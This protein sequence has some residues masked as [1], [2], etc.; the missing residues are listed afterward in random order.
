MAVVPFSYVFFMGSWGLLLWSDSTLHLLKPVLVF[1]TSQSLF[2]CR[3][4]LILSD[5][6]IYLFLS[7]SFLR[8]PVHHLLPVNFFFIVCPRTIWKITMV[9]ECIDT[10]P[11]SEQSFFWNAWWE[12]SLLSVLHLPSLSSILSCNRS[13]LN[14]FLE[15][16]ISCAAGLSLC[17]SCSRK[18][19]INI[20]WCYTFSQRPVPLAFRE[21]TWAS[22]G[23]RTPVAFVSPV[24]LLVL[25]CVVFWFRCVVSV[26]TLGSFLWFVCFHLFSPVSPSPHIEKHCWSSTHVAA[27]V[28]G[29]GGSVPTFL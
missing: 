18:A 17:L 11:A 7:T 24:E 9:L 5:L 15:C 12:P 26:L 19:K 22:L 1:K 2:S 25:C 8:S 6:F 16:I 13:M 3:M 29:G 4:K 10:N 20:Y 21:T 28:L 27:G 23:V 14:D